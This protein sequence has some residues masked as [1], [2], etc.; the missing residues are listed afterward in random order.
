M[1]K[2]EYLHD[3]DFAVSLLRRSDVSLHDDLDTSDLCLSLAE[4]RHEVIHENPQA[5][6]TVIKSANVQA[7]RLEQWFAECAI[8]GHEA[9][10]NAVEVDPR[11]RGGI[12]VLKGT[13]FTVGQTLAELAESEGVPEVAERCNLDEATIREL[14]HGLALLVERPCR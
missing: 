14:L 11:R 8:W 2:P 5:W 1:Q 7:L 13:R 4:Q 10:Q 9:L 12:P 6:R 3:R